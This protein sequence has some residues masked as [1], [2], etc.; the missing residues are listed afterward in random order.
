MRFIGLWAGLAVLGCG[1]SEGQLFATGQATGG[2]TVVE[3]GGVPGTGGA[4]GSGGQSVGTGGAPGSGGVIGSGGAVGSGGLAPVDAG[5]GGK[6]QASGGRLGTGGANQFPPC[7][8][9]WVACFGVCVLD[10]TCSGGSGGADGAVGSG[11]AVSNGGS[12]S[13]GGIPGTGGVCGWVQIMTTSTGCG[14]PNQTPCPSGPAM[15]LTERCVNL[16]DQCWACSF[17]CMNGYEP[18]PSGSW[19]CVPI[20]S[21]AGG[22]P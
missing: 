14:N 13:T 18:S 2:E 5:A 1:G 20:P 21:G 7:S 19:E 22:A 4:V 9:G 17:V 16:H 12:D 8:P 11:G 6:P 10:G 3:T 15:S